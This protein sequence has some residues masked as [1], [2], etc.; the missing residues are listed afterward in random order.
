MRR[1]LRDLLAMGLVEW[2]PMRGKL[3]VAAAFRGEAPINRA[4]RGPTWKR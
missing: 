2:L 1:D 4:L 3:R